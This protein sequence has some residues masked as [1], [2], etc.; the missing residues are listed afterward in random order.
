MNSLVSVIYEWSFANAVYGNL[1]QK[2][3]CDRIRTW[4]LHL[5]SVHRN[6]IQTF[7]SSSPF[8]LLYCTVDAAVGLKS[9][10]THF[11]FAIRM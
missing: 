10:S 1:V 4:V 11:P 6:V 7:A 5:A 8:E 3:Y 9:N 2:T